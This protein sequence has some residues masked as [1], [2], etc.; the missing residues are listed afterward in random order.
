MCQKRRCVGNFAQKYLAPCDVLEAKCGAQVYVVVVDSASGALS[1]QGLGDCYLQ[2][3]LVDGRRLELEG[4]RDDALTS[5]ELLTNKAG[6]PLLAHGRSGNHSDEYRVVV[7]MIAGQAMLPD[8]KVTDSSEALLAG[9][10]P[11][12]R[13]LARVIHRGGMP[14]AGI[15]PVLSEPF[16][17]ATARVKGAAKAEIPHIDDHISKLEGLGVQT[18]KK[19][20]NISSAASAAN[21]YNLQVP[22]NSVTKV[23]QFLELVEFAERSKPLRETLKQVLRLTKGWDVAREHVRKAVH[24]D[25][26]L[27]VFHPDWNT[28]AGPVFRSGAFNV[29]DIEH[30]VGLLRKRKQNGNSNEEIVDVLWLGTDSTSWPEA[31][32][33]L[34]PQAMAA[35]WK[36]G[37]P[38]WAILPLTISHL[39]EIDDNGRPA[40]SLSTFS[41]STKNK[42]NIWDRNDLQKGAPTSGTSFTSNLDT[43]AP[44]TEDIR[45]ANKTASSQQYA[46]GFPAA[47]PEYLPGMIPTSAVG[48]GPSEPISALNTVVPPTANFTGNKYSG[49]TSATPFE[50]PMFQQMM[51]AVA[52]SNGFNGRFI[53]VAGMISGSN[54]R[55]F[56][57]PGSDSD[58]GNSS[59]G[60]RKADNSLEMFLQD[61]KSLDQDISLPPNFAGMDSLAADAPPGTT[62]AIAAAAAQVAAGALRDTA[63][64]NIF[65]SPGH[66]ASAF[67]VPQSFGALDNTLTGSFRFDSLTADVERDKGHGNHVPLMEFITAAQ[68]QRRQHRHQQQNSSNKEVTAPRQTSSIQA[69]HSSAQG[70]PDSAPAQIP[71]G[72]SMGEMRSMFAKAA[73]Q[74]I[75]FEELERYLQQH[76]LLSDD[77]ARG[78][79][80]ASGTKSVGND[81]DHGESAYNDVSSKDGTNEN[82][83][84][85]FAGNAKESSKQVMEN[86]VV[87]SSLVSFEPSGVSM[88]PTNIQPDTE[89][90]PTDSLRPTFDGGL[91]TMRS[92]EREL[93]ITNSKV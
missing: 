17:V 28:E 71:A 35:W 22:H 29:I 43:Q 67:S 5:Y 44:S 45:M 75:S 16:V 88:L 40:Q 87:Q 83:M 18:Q 78:S 6:H 72:I 33:R 51:Q 73:K 47:A 63:V 92:M 60:K 79:H 49:A 27:K 84:N 58:G 85:A 19:L 81:E 11:P 86:G 10:A 89:M 52:S 30:P 69:S 65:G 39:P 61:H 82:P 24:T 32:R 15:G 37:H 48:I 90:K 13:L 76:G 23:G 25:R 50:D 74:K 2:L 14:V 41:F 38:G 80:G 93:P 64:G 34:V 8:L 55:Q 42:E 59:K 68:N 57:A 20:E 46:S 77:T 36:E 7:P 31:V 62:K 4:P 1:P 56:R 54:Q 12:F 70:I 3:S 53:D 26:S 21:I 9:R 66:G 91:D